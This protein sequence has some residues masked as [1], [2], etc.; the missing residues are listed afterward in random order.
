VDLIGS[1]EL[2]ERPD[3]ACRSA[4]WFWKVGAG[5]NL[6]KLALK[7]CGYGCNLNDIADKGD[8]KAITAAIQGAY[9]GYQE[10]LAYYERAQ[11][12]LV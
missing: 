4:A 3:L 8:F 5:L 6:S 2:L 1:P 10:R 11:Q 12:V 9:G 7:L